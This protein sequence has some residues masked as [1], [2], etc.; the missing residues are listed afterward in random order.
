MIGSFK[1]FVHVSVFLIPYRI[2]DRNY[3]AVLFYVCFDFAVKPVEAFLHRIVSVSQ[4]EDRELI[5]ADTEYRAV[6]KVLAYKRTGILYELI[7]RCM[8]LI[9]FCM[10]LSLMRTAIS[11]SVSSIGA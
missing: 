9:W 3:N 1:Y 4:K 11:K 10:T 8:T 6:L 2:S 5:A 7:A